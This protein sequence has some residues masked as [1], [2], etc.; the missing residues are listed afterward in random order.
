MKDNIILIHPGFRDCI[1]FDVFM[2]EPS[3]EIEEDLY[4]T[5]ECPY[6]EKFLKENPNYTYIG[7]EDLLHAFSTNAAIL[8]FII[9]LVTDK[10]VQLIVRV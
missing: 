6:V 2:R 9:E 3:T 4:K 5:E 8:R 10:D 1:A 7:S